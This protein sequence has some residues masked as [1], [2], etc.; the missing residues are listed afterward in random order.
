MP[1]RL[2]LKNGVL[3]MQDGTDVTEYLRSRPMKDAPEVVL[4]TRDEAERLASEAYAYRMLHLS[5][6][7]RFCIAA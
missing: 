5:D 6:D 3:E 4:L 1:N 2:C 7:E